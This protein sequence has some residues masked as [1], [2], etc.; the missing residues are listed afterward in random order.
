MRR[1]RFY[2]DTSV[3]GGCFDPEFAEWSRLLIDD[4]RHRRL[5]A[6]V[7]DLVSTEVDL[8]PRAV[9]A[10]YDELVGFESEL[11]IVTR[12]VDDLAS[13]Y[14][15]RG[16]LSRRSRNDMLHVALASLARVDALVSWDFRH[17]VRLDNVRAFSAVNS[18]FGLPPITIASPPEVTFYGEA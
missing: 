17:L 7:S 10:Q 4:F 6:V 1:Y 18:A 9:R 8:A 12:E 3:I 16:V 14:E 5:R 2:V 11:L 13:A 15:E